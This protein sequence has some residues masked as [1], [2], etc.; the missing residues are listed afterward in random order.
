[1]GLWGFC[2]KGA[3]IQSM[4]L[5]PKSI[6]GTIRYKRECESGKTIRLK[7]NADWKYYYDSHSG[8]FCM[9]R[10]EDMDGGIC[11]AIIKN[12]LVVLSNGKIKAIWIKPR[13]L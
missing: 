10:V 2:P 13:F 3:W 4:L 1:M 6:T 5:P 7:E 9:K 12:V 11:V 8:W